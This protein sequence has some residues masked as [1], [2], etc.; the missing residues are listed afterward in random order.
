MF[1][2]WTEWAVVI[3]IMSVLVAL[4][5][6]QAVRSPRSARRLQCKDNLKQIGLALHRYAEEWGG[7]PPAYT[8]DADGRKLHSWRTLILPYLDQQ[9]LYEQIDLTKPWDALVNEK[10]RKTVLSA[11]NCPSDEGPEQ[12]TSYLAFVGDHLAFHPT[13]PRSFSEI[14]DGLCNTLMVMEVPRN[15]TFD[16]MAPDDANEQTFLAVH[17]ESPLSH[18]GGL[19]VLLADGSARYVSVLLPKETRRGLMTIDGG[20]TLEEF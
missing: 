8:V 17:P 6:P 11:Y 18:R 3:L 13:R 15:Q 2:S 7:F 4:L 14:T 19:Q 5:L 10:A 12:H 1:L 20:E 16:W 9:V